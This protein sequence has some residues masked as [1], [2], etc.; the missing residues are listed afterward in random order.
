MKKC[1]IVVDYQRDF[2]DGSLG[3]EGGQ[4]IK[5][6][7]MSKIKL[8]RQNHDDIIFTKDTHDKNYLDTEE[9][10]YLNVVHCLKGSDGHAIEKDVDA[11]R[12]KEDYVFEKSTF[13]SLELGNYLKKR[14]YQ[15]IELCGLVSNICVISNAV[16][17]K[18]ALPNAHLVVDAQATASAN[19][20]LHK[21]SLD[22]M[23]GLHIEVKN[24]E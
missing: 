14:D 10:Q 17:A 24:Y 16:I 5:D 3:F 21:K 4:I 9:G 1:L 20:D 19:Q 2:I 22:V 12:K 13:P 15:E 8:Y 7:I 11:L 23:E 18:A 6:K